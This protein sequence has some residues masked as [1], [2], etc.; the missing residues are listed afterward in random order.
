MTILKLVQGTPEWLAHR[1]KYRNA[2]ESPAVMGVS[3]WTT[4]YQLWL[5]RTGRHVRP[6]TSAMTRGL[7]LEPA[8]RLAYEKLSGLV[9]EPLV[10][11]EGEYS[12]SLDGI[13]MEGDLILEIKCPVRGRDSPLWQA[14]EAK[15]LPEHYRWQVEHQLMVAGAALAHVYVFDGER[16]ILLEQ[17]PKPES[18]ESIRKAWDA[19]MRYI[20]ED[21]APPLSSRDT[22]ERD[23]A[24][25]KVAAEA[26]LRI[27]QEAEDSA[28]VLE[29][30]RSA[31]V[32][33]TSHPSESGAGVSVSQFW[34][35]G[36]VEYKKIP[37]LTGV[38]L[39]T[40]RKESRM[41]VRVTAA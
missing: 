28:A 26:Y 30:A 14:V 9:L 33:L 32:A 13:T 21:V 41:E 36:A 40:Y 23:D 8:A 10:L 17:T 7:E 12:A 31:L 3:P 37:Q 25:W 29:K 19:F 18:W 2:S 38:D 4:P 1:R 5:E 39:E 15:E 20:V 35:K 22:R 11:T 34:K 27:K 16:G 6:V 24:Q